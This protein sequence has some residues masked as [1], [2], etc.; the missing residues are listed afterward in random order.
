M[1]SKN[2]IKLIL[3]SCVFAFP[4]AYYLTYLGLRGFSYKIDINWWMIVLPGV[5]VLVATLLTI[6][7][8]SIRASLTNPAKVLK[9]Q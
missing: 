5:I 8:Q 7:T 3:I 6:S 2:Y 4:V 9:D 1:L